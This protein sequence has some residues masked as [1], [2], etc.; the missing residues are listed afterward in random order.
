MGVREAAALGDGDGGVLWFCSSSSVSKSRV[1]EILHYL[2]P[3]SM[4]GL[5]SIGYRAASCCLCGCACGVWVCVI[6]V[7]KDLG[8][9][10]NTARQQATSNKRTLAS[11][12]IILSGLLEK[13]SSVI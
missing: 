4:L 13:C 11:G 3:R 6:L 12:L 2:N 1:A 10:T 9:R 5:L 8:S 7:I